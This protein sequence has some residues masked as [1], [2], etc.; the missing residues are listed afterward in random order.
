[1]VKRRDI[2]P[3]IFPFYD[4]K[5][6]NMSLAVQKGNYLFISGHTASEYDQ[7]IKKMVCKGNM[8][9]QAEVCYQKIK[10]LVKA[11]GGN[12]SDVVKLIEYIAP[13]GISEYHTVDEVKH[14]YFGDDLPAVSPIGVHNLLRPGAFMEVEALA[15]LGSDKQVLNTEP[16]V[17]GRL[18]TPKAITKG[19]LLF[20]A[21]QYGTDCD[22]KIA[23]K[24]DIAAQTE[25]AYRNIN[26]LLERLG[27]TF[28]DVVKINDYI[29]AAGVARYEDSRK[30]RARYFRDGYPAV[31]EAVVERLP[32]EDALIEIDCI[33]V[34]GG[35]KKTYDIDGNPF[36][37]AC[38]PIVKK[39]NLV[40]FSSLA[41]IDMKTGML[42]EGDVVAQM[43]QLCANADKLL[44]TAEI[45]WKDVLK[46]VDY[47]APE[48]GVNYRDTA[49][50]RRQY[51]G[52]ALPA[53]TGVFMNQL[54]RAGSLV[55]VD[56]VAVAD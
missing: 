17:P 56:F 15:V 29:T 9:E 20:I 39:G 6:Y 26:Y 48:G 25:Q 16:L 54:L 11:G 4:Y 21:G 2:E 47:I 34:L 50:I 14:R 53:S 46:T 23:G 55:Q 18:A 43:N 30:V 31:T 22:G 51:F 27:A 12:I 42:V 33:A 28:N 36:A 32:L 52:E 3:E 5:R 1:M 37:E 38:S 45:G 41:S 44:G 13:I 19:N 40:F 10:L 7:E 35:K 8:S 24:G 49:S